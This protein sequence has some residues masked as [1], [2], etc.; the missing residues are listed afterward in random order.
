MNLDSDEEDRKFEQTY[1][2]VPAF[3]LLENS[4]VQYEEIEEHLTDIMH[5]ING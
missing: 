2:E 3:G 5:V 1:T 4:L